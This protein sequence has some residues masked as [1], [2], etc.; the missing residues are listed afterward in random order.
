VD[1]LSD[2]AASFHRIRLPAAV[3]YG[4]VRV[5]A[6]GRA[7]VRGSHDYAGLF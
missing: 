1:S 3:K 5:G 2:A 4:P 7:A 6:Y